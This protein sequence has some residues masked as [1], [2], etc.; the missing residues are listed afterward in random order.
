MEPPPGEPGGSGGSEA[1]RI[2][3]PAGRGR[4]NAIGAGEGAELTKRSAAPAEPG[5]SGASAGCTLQQSAHCIMAGELQ[6]AIIISWQ[7]ERFAV[8][9]RQAS[10]GIATQSTATTSITNAPFLPTCI[11]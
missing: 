2:V 8:G 7:Q 4:A 6:P 3:S 9:V 10:A 1:G 11:V 5:S